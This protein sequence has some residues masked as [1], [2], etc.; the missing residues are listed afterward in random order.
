MLY[1]LYGPDDFSIHQAMERIKTGLGDSQMLEISTSKL[2]GERLTLREMKDNC[3]VVPFLSSYRLVIVNGLLKRF[4]P[5]QNKSRPGRLPAKE[6][7]SELGEWQDLP[8]H[9]EQTPATT[10]LIFIDGM[11][12]S[13]NP[14]LK[15]LHPLA[16][17]EFFPLLRGSNLKAWIERG[18]TEEGGSITPEAVNL[19]AEFVGG[20]LWIMN[21]EIAKLLLYVQGR[22]IDEDDVKQ[23]ASYAQ[24]TSI[25]AL[26]DAVLEGQ[27][28]I[29]Q[30]ILH[31]LYQEGASAT[32][33]LAMITRQFRLAVQA[34][35][36]APGLSR[37][38]IQHRLGLSSSYSLDKTLSQAGKYN[39]E[40]IKEA[41]HKLLNTDLAIKTGK[42]NDQ[43]A[44][45]LLVTELASSRV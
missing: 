14:L 35:E 6:I 9:L 23:M 1:I 42:Y 21:N 15:R 45:E 10:V 12:S 20:N 11:I 22:P 13:H 18:V 25:F 41:Y 2:D 8:S 32:Y 44:L 27:T 43:L 5:R 36:L 16:K 7:R 24:E 17:V 30:Q 40:Q 39:F 26:V 37:Q 33:I 38:Q 28:K 4:E 34:R 29:A 3:N 19:L 31:R